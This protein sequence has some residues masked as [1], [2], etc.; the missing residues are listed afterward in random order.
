VSHVSC[1]ILISDCD[2]SPAGMAALLLATTSNS[3]HITPQAAV[4]QPISNVA[5]TPPIS[6]STCSLD[7][8]LVAP[9]TQVPLPCPSE[10]SSRI[11]GKSPTSRQLPRSD[12]LI[13]DIPLHH[14][15]G[16][17][18]PESNSWRE[19]VEH[20]QNGDPAR[21]LHTPLKDWLPEWLRGPNKIFAM[22]YHH[23]A[24]IAREFLNVSVSI[25]W[26]L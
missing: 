25:H 5:Q 3:G 21:G 19:I 12:L 22:K 10:A 6:T 11:G 18:S 13:P 16:T 9:S 8:T 20:W 14:L 2:G 26:K 24:V 4:F 1:R 15:D 17:R 7:P 23:H